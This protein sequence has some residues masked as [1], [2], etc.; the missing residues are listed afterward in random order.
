MTFSNVFRSVAIGAVALGHALYSSP[1]SELLVL[2]EQSSFHSQETALEKISRLFSH[3]AS[4]EMVIQNETD[5]QPPLLLNKLAVALLGKTGSHSYQVGSKTLPKAIICVVNGINNCKEEAMQHVSKISNLA[6]GLLIKGI[7]NASNFLPIDIIEC[8][9]GHMGIHTP[10]VPL[11][12]REWH[13]FA[14]SHPP[15]AKM[16]LICH[17]GGACHVKNA[18]L[19]APSELRSR[20]IVVAIAPSVIIP[21]ELCHKATNYTSER[22]FVTALDICGRIRHG[23]QLRVLPAHPQA[24]LWDH[25]LDSPTFKGV[26][27]DAIK[28]YTASCAEL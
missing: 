1:Y 19:E 27:E 9:I 14:E 24:S 20:I 26:L 17:S 2:Q 3:F 10:P 5:I 23:D 16:L 8:V 18:L 6:Q 25:G 12:L 15:K 7:Y 21:N 11:L 28:D 22:D 4:E 13:K